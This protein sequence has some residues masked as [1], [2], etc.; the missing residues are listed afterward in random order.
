MYLMYI[1]GDTVLNY[2]ERMRTTIQAAFRR[3]TE[4][5][6]HEMSQIAFD[7]WQ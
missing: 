7:G 2:S 3:M 1:T 6:K 4:D 5:W